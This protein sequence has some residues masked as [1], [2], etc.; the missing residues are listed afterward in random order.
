MRH[1]TLDDHL[2]FKQPEIKPN[3]KVVLF[4]VVNFLLSC[5]AVD[6]AL[7]LIA[8]SMHD[9]IWGYLI[10][11]VE[12]VKLSYWVISILIY[13]TIIYKKDLSFIYPYIAV[14]G[15]IFGFLGYI[16]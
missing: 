8:V 14:V 15:T 5:K 7:C 11:D 2:F 10:V 12:F 13:M 4:V 1:E 16:L 3:L 9:Y 6:S